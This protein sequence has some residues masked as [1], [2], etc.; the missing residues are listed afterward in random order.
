MRMSA[1]D[2]TGATARQPALSYDVVLLS[3][4]SD[5]AV[6]AANSPRPK[7]PQPSAGPSSETKQQ[8]SN[9]EVGDAELD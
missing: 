5:W 3:E 6:P 4:A 1:A 2:M 9:D 8:R 7:R